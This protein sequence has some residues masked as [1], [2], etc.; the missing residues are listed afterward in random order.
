MLTCFCNIYISHLF[1]F[2]LQ[3]P[4]HPVRALSSCAE[5]ELYSVFNRHRLQRFL[6]CPWVNKRH[7]IAKPV[8]FIT[9][10]PSR[11]LPKVNL[12]EGRY[13]FHQDNQLNSLF[14]RPDA[15]GSESPMIVAH[16]ILTEFKRLQILFCIDRYPS[17]REH[18]V[19]DI[20]LLPD[21]LNAVFPAVLLDIFVFPFLLSCVANQDHLI[22]TFHSV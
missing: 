16:D 19:A 21:H 1:Q 22:T 20:A 14:L 13:L 17:V 10:F 7:R 5:P 2:S 12:S 6:E 18:I 15:F 3:I 4:D 11:H 8:V 9:A